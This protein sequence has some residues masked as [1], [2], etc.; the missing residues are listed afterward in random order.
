MSVPCR[1]C[2]AT[3]WHVAAD[4][5]EQPLANRFRLPADAAP[6]PRYGLAVLVCEACLLVQL[7]RAVPPEVLF[8][9]YAYLSSVS[10]SW[11][12]HAERF[13]AASCARF[14]LDAGSHVLEVASND[15]YLLRGFVARGISC[16]GIE[17]AAGI[18][19]VARA[20]GVPTHAAF[21]GDAVAA[22]LETP[23][24]LVIANN[25][26]AHAPSLAD[27]VAGLA[28]A[29][30]PGGVLSIEV[31]HVACLLRDG[32]FDTIYHEHVFYFS[33]LA[34]TAVLAR[35]GLSV[36][37]VERL[38]THGGSL[39]VFAQGLG[40]RQTVTDRPAA[41]L[42]EE[43]RAGLDRPESY[44]VI[45]AA[46][47]QAGGGLRRWREEARRCGLHV[48]AYGAA[49]KG[50]MLLNMAGFTA[51]DVAMVADANPL[52]QGRLM[53]GSGIPVVTP[54]QLRA[55]RPDLVLIL[56]WNIADEVA[57]SLGWVSEWGGRLVVPG[58]AL[59]GGPCG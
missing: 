46:A 12:A 43:R 3:L 53:P 29:L 10:A 9:D 18:A 31:P 27:F 28:R 20:Q 21:F 19:A 45:Q 4:F 36:F 7:E 39:R 57:A 42:A 16:L 14:G 11:L 34:L 47:R 1:H 13:V 51:E 8:A 6:E 24:D 25:V 30:A 44:D 23:A 5:G 49:A 15:G 41:M 22:A 59:W 26:L 58:P 32:Q 35:A 55:A 2:G 52:K 54:E 37:D 17:P 33:L 40:G 56:P 48:A 38:S 50:A